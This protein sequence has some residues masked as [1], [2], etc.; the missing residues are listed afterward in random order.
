MSVIEWRAETIRDPLERLRFLRNTVDVGAVVPPAA[1]VRRS[2]R[3]T[4]RAGMAVAALLTIVAFMASPTSSISVAEYRGQFLMP[5]PA[6]QPA[7]EEAQKVWQVEVTR[8]YET[9]SNG[10][11]VEKGYQTA[12]NERVPYPVYRRRDPQ[13]ASSEM[14][15]GPAGIV[16]H[17]TESHMAPFEPEQNGQIRR[18]ETS[19]LDLLRRNRSYHY[20]IDR[21]GR[22]FRIVSEGDVANHAGLSIWADERYAYVN[23]NA[24]FL[25]VSFETQ[26]R[27]G[28]DNPEISPAQIHSARIL[29][30]MLRYKYAIPAGN[31]VTHAQVSVNPSNMRIGY[32][33]DWAGN[34]PFSEIG[35]G[36]NYEEPLASVFA[37]GF[38][39]DGVFVQSTGRRLWQG[40]RTSDEQ[41]TLQAS[42]LGMPVPA[43]KRILRQRYEKILAATRAATQ[44]GE[45]NE[46]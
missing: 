17:T 34:F 27:R 9:Y 3:K 18:I 35:L 23:L 2:R 16:Y 31:C 19:V 4:I 8:D 12:G 41:V 22:V 45:N 30:D 6:P 5:P 32:H 26:T 11:R 24:S 13:L 29:T 44:K 20:M 15:S 37:F 25:G 10:L 46:E 39:Y 38:D 40:L 21:F 1:P 43:Y 14:R 7:G 42:V 36:D 33:T 28:E